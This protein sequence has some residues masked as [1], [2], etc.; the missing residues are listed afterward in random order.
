MDKTRSE[1]AEKIFKGDA[2][3]QRLKRERDAKIGNLSTEFYNLI[4]ECNERIDK[5]CKRDAEI[6]ILSREYGGRLDKRWKE[7]MLCDEDA[8]AKGPENE[9]NSGR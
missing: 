4:R 5:L 2:E 7:Y 6:H 8:E 3:L 1:R 9:R